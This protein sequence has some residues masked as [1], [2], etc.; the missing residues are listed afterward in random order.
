[1]A[2]LTI[3]TGVN[4]ALADSG[5]KFVALSMYGKGKAFGAAAVLLN[6]QGDSDAKEYVVL[7]FLS[8]S[9]ECVLKGLLLLKDCETYSGRLQKP[10]GH[11]L[12]KIATA[13]SIA[14][15]RDPVRGPLADEIRALSN[16]YSKHRLRYGMVSDMFIDPRTIPHARVFRRLV[17]VTRL[18]E[19]E[20]RRA[21]IT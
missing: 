14:F 15:G 7:H 9:I 10:L 11:N 16:F 18:A 3:T 4:L 20:L 21:H 19:R 8:H 5:K 2:N 13:A 17:A 12:F 1:V 6:R